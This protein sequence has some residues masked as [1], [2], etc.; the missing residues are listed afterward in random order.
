M[1]E[2][3]APSLIP[4]VAKAVKTAFAFHRHPDGGSHDAPRRTALVCFLSPAVL[5]RGDNPFLSVFMCLP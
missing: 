1:H 4:D 5:D 3:F 2:Q